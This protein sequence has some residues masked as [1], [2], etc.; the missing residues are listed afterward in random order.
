MTSGDATDFVFDDDALDLA[1]G[2]NIKR[3]VGSGTN[4][5]YAILGTTKFT[6]VQVEVAVFNSDLP[7]TLG[8]PLDMV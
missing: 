2:E 4:G 6:D 3:S 1:P 7:N 8:L 5:R